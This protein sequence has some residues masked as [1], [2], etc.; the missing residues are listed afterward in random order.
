V[1]S[2]YHIDAVLVDLLPRSIPEIQLGL[3]LRAVSR[4]DALVGFE[5]VNTANTNAYRIVKTLYVSL[6]NSNDNA[7]QPK[8]N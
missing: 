8:A 5:A 6:R 7:F 2:V 3:P 1:I 4:C